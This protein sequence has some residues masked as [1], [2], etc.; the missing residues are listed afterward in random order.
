M[1]RQGAQE[2]VQSVEANLGKIVAQ[3]FAWK[4]IIFYIECVQSKD[5]WMVWLHLFNN[6]IWTDEALW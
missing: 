6:Q 1:L 4:L 2:E 5:K 3:K